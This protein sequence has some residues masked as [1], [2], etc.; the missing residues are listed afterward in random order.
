MSFNIQPEEIATLSYY[1]VMNFTHCREQRNQRM[2]KKI[3]DEIEEFLQDFEEDVYEDWQDDDIDEFSFY[4]TL[5]DFARH[6]HKTLR[7]R[8]HQLKNEFQTS[9]TAIYKVVKQFFEWK[10]DY[11]HN[12]ENDD[13][14]QFL[15]PQRLHN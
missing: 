3:Y 2:M 5:K 6:I 10:L 4:E 14:I 9:R 15:I 8:N 7:C 1:F 13:I 12:N 11:N